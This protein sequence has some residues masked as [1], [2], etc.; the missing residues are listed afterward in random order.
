MSDSAV[1]VAHHAMA[2]GSLQRTQEYLGRGRAWQSALEGE[3]RSMFLLHFAQWRSEPLVQRTYLND[4]IAEYGLRGL[5]PPYDAVK[6]D[7]DFITKTIADALAAMPA[8]QHDRI[9]DSLLEDFARS[10]EKKQ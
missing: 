6:E 9:N 5:E 10:T 3:L 4:V 2:S 1:N 8:D 7:L